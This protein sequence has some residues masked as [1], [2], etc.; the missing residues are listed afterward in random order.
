MNSNKKVSKISPDLQSQRTLKPRRNNDVIS[1]ID[2]LNLKDIHSEIIGLKSELEHVQQQVYRLDSIL[3]IR[4]K[5]W[6]VL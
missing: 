1:T 4:R 6:E 5:L 2:K 3:I